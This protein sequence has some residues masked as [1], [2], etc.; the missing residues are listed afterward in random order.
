M[1]SHKE[2]QPNDNGSSSNVT[3]TRL[4]GLKAAAATV[5]PL[6]ALKAAAGAPLPV[7]LG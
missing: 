3:A 6:S 5:A 1:N 4:S 7:F 2:I